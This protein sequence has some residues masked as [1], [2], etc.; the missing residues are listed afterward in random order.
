MQYPPGCVVIDNPP[1]SLLSQIVDF[2]LSQRIPF[3]LFSPAVTVLNSANRDGVCA[4]ISSA[5]VIYENGASLRTSFLT[6]LDPMRIVVTPELHTIVEEASR[7]VQLEIGALKELPRY[8]YPIEVATSIRLGWLAEHGTGLEISPTECVHIRALDMQKQQ[9]KG[10]YGSGVLL[11]HI[12][13]ERRAAAERA[14]AEQIA[15]EQAT[16]EQV[17]AYVWQLSERERKII[18]GLK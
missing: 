14:A 18:D 6:S 3:F 11:G 12:A 4:V 2:Y 16:D 9:G 13:A 1:F 7:R 17:P 8:T 10:I 15:A 5:R